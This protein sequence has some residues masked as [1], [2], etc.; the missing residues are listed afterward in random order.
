MKISICIP[1]YEMRGHG[2]EFLGMNLSKIASQTFK[3]YEV[4]VSDHSQDNEIYYLCT[5]WHLRDNF[6]I[7]YIRNEHNRGS[8][9]ANINNAMKFA[10]GEWIKI[11]F[12][13]D[14]F[15]ASDSLQKTVDALVDMDKGWLAT[16][17]EHTP[18]G[19]IFN[20][21][22]SPNWNSSIHLGINSIGSPTVITLRNTPDKP[23]FDEKLI[24]L[25]DCDYYRSL[26]DKWGMP[27]LIPDIT[28][29]NRM[30]NERL[31]NTISPER[32]M[33]EYIKM[34]GKYGN[35]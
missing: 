33:D 1:T 14:F 19:V 10:M 23:L 2:T 34:R 31:S 13:D 22:M 4:V 18:D 32:K 20:R 29:V 21:P 9:S 16:G 25:M 7:R 28:V 8:S 17:A 26:H 35:V 12:Q 5:A 15:Y 3:D 24:W 30:W 11:I 6:P 27:K